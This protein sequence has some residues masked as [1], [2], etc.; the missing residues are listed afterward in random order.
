MT[1]Q[2]LKEEEIDYP[3]TYHGEYGSVP[4]IELKHKCPCCKKKALFKR[5]DVNC[6][7]GMVYYEGYNMP[8]YR[9]EKCWVIIGFGVSKMKEKK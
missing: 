8:L 3:R 2:E 5:I 9:C 7:K 6:D 4:Y 1:K